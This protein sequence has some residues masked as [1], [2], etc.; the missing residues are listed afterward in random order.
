MNT[1]NTTTVTQGTASLYPTASNITLA[2]V[3]ADITSP[4]NLP[5]G[6]VPN[7]VGPAGDAPTTPSSGIPDG[8][9][10][11]LDAPGAIPETAVPRGIVAGNEI[12][13]WLAI[14]IAIVV[15]SFVGGFGMFAY[16]RLMT[17]AKEPDV[18]QGATPANHDKGSP[19]RVP[20]VVRLFATVDS[21]HPWKKS[22]SPPGSLQPTTG[23]VLNTLPS[24]S[25]IAPLPASL[26]YAHGRNA[27]YFANFRAKNKSKGD[28]F[29][30]ATQKTIDRIQG[31]ATYERNTNPFHPR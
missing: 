26:Q 28:A 7:L 5:V 22:F 13:L 19:A 17:R 25:P 30:Q 8:I 9:V 3:S 23:I 4:N 15:L 24:I 29:G 11:G 1:T 21:L 14:L 16:H 31:W 20:F 2:V 27:A 12:H 18:E 6:V 10:P